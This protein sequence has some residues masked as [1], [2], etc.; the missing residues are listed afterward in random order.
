[1]PNEDLVCLVPILRVPDAETSAAWYCEALGF[2]VVACESAPGRPTLAVRR[3]VATLHLQTAGRPSE[4]E[5]WIEVADLAGFVE[6]LADSDVQTQPSETPTERLLLTPDGTRLRIAQAEVEREQAPDAEASPEPAPLETAGSIYALRALVEGPF[7][8]ASRPEDLAA[9][10]TFQAASRKAAS[11]HDE[12][13]LVSYAYGTDLVIALLAHGALAVQPG[14]LRKKHFLEV[15]DNLNRFHAWNRWFALQTLLARAKNP[16]RLLGR[17]LTRLDSAW[18]TPPEAPWLRDWVTA[19]LDQGGIAELAEPPTGAL[20]A[21]DEDERKVLDKLVAAALPTKARVAYRQAIDAWTALQIDTDLLRKIG[22]VYDGG[23]AP[24]P[25]PFRHEALDKAAA[26]IVTA[27]ERR[28]PV[29]VI[30]DRGI[31]K[32]AALREAARLM[33]AQGWVWFTAGHTELIAGQSFIGQFEGQ[34]RS[35]VEAAKGRRVVWCVPDVHTLVNTGRHSKSDV[36]AMDYLVGQLR[37]GKLA[38]VGECG[39]SEGESLFQAFP[40]MRALAVVQRGAPLGRTA[41]L[42]L[43]A[44]ILDD[45]GQATSP[46]TLEEGWRL[47]REY[48]RT[49][50]APGSL[51]ELIRAASE[52]IEGDL[53]TQ[54]LVRALSALT[55]LPAEVVDHRQHLDLEALK[56]A[57]EGEVMGQPHAVQVLLDRIALVKAGLTDPSRPLAVLLFAGPTGTGKTQLAKTLARLL[58]GDPD[59]MVRVDMSELQTGDAMASIVGGPRNP[60]AL[61]AAVQREPYSVVLLDE[62]EK[63]AR[64]IWDLFLQVFDDGRLTDWHGTTVDFRQTIVV[65]T[66]NLGAAVAPRLG[67]GGTGAQADEAILDTVKRTFRPEFLNRIDHTVVFSTLS[68]ATM[69][70][71]LYKELGDARNRRGLRN[72]DVVMEWD[73]TAVAHLLESGFAPELGARPL[74]RA[75]EQQLL[76]PLAR[77]MVTAAF[78]EEAWLMVRERAGALAIDVLNMAEPSLPQAAAAGD[79]PAQIALDGRG[80]PEQAAALAK[81]LDA[82]G[83]VVGGAGW[84]QAKSAA[85]AAMSEPS[86]W[87]GDRQPAVQYERRD[88]VETALETA[89]RWLA[90]LRQERTPRGRRDLARRLARRVLLLSQAIAA[91]EQGE[92]SDCILSLEPIDGAILGGEALRTMYTRWAERCGLRC[93]VL[94]QAPWTIAVVGFGAWATLRNEQGL[95]RFVHEEARTATKGHW[96]VRVGPWPAGQEGD[97]K[98]AA[99]ALGPR[100]ATPEVAR[101]YRLGSAPLVRGRAARTGR[102]DRVLDGDFDLLALG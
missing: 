35:V 77:M 58:F 63:A 75:V 15:L 76:V 16:S 9:H 55:G 27:L 54:H 38:F 98:A 62:F 79:E 44:S 78:P 88:R 8:I 57:F 24:W 18:L 85:L 39:T 47:V 100:P 101:R 13:T 73:E 70:S 30:G 64:P 32:T 36:G 60:D 99:V 87:E 97:A 71:I 82:L 22:S 50:H 66:S 53:T 90:R 3:G 80:S 95:H 86:F 43:A 89:V 37:L 6:A 14:H 61:A 84:R 12:A 31:G 93:S 33:V 67:F 34:L 11:L 92:P 7:D 29:L 81:H 91:L 2:E 52:G 10:P 46:G 26:S 45:E 17:V 5:V 20:A 56:N 42:A 102:I 83:E 1:M 69:R 40:A 41:T 28:T 51:L 96:L 65:M 94:S 49:L 25:L 74:K 4:D 19:L 21:K 59:R 68:R 72:R 48:N 23:E